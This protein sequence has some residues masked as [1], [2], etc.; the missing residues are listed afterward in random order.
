MPKVIVRQSIEKTLDRNSQWIDFAKYLKPEY[1]VSFD[2][3][4]KQYLFNVSGCPFV[5]ESLEKTFILTRLPIVP[6]GTEAIQDGLGMD[7][8]HEEEVVSTDRNKASTKPSTRARS[9]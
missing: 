6:A 4:S 8:Q 5:L 1:A 9:E 2:S 3:E 7:A